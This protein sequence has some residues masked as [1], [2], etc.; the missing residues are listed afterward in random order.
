MTTTPPD[1]MQ[2]AL[3]AVR[4]GRLKDATALIQDNL[5][6]Q[7]SRTKGSFADL[8]VPPRRQGPIP[9]GAKAA[10][11]PARERFTCAAGSREYLLHL[12]E[13]DP[14][15]LILML[16]GCT[17]TPEDFAVG[18]TMSA[19]GT[20]AGLAVLYAAQSRGDNAQSCWNWFSAADQ[21]RDRGE[22]AI[23]AGMVRAVAAQNGV[24]EDRIFVAGL[25][26]GAAMAVILGRAYPDMF[27]A[28]G[29]HSGLPYGAARSVPEAFSAMAGEHHPRKIDG[30]G[31]PVPTIVFH[32]TKDATVSPANGAR[33][34]ADTLSGTAQTIETTEQG[35]TAGRSFQRTVH[36]GPTQN[37]L[38]EEWRIE[39]LGHAWS[40]GDAK[41][42][43][44]DPKGPDATAQMI[45]F[46]L[47]VPRAGLM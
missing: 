42:S 46:F 27:T 2:R 28:V 40:G 13:G 36:S 34:V 47:S 11:H 7:S 30:T 3:Q 44:A 19:K 1:A 35:Q 10:G 18:T 8:A 31:Q 4:S 39:G 22:P 26:A 38:S 21:R 16:H 20:A 32:G 17:Q 6:W 37:V 24:P 29:A 5:G 33:I 41:G 45:R 23:L 15:G 9:R 25:S 43:Y 12:P 14:R